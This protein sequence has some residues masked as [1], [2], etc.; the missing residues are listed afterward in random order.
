MASFSFI[1]LLAALHLLFFVSGAPTPAAAPAPQGGAG[2]TAASSYWLAS[3]A[4]NGK[5]AYGNPNFQIF[6]NVK[7]FGAK[8]DGTVT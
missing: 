4:R 1:A 5:A 8:G 3:I 6:R 2:N 7:D